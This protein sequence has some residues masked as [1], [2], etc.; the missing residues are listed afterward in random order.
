MLVPPGTVHAFS[1]PGPDPATLLIMFCPADHREQYF[2][3]I[4]DLTRD[5]RQPSREELVS[6]MRRFDQEPV[7]EPG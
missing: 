1:N 4:A 7:D 6:L 3:G 5:G 2:E